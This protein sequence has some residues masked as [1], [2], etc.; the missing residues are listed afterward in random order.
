LEAFLEAFLEAPL[1]AKF[2]PLFDGSAFCLSDEELGG[3]GH[4]FLQNATR[5]AEYLTLNFSDL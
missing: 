3:G 2:E 5:T 4:G 1:N